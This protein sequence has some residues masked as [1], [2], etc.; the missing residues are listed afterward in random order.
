MF[1]YFLSILTLEANSFKCLNVSEKA[2]LSPGSA[3]F[4]RLEEEVS[5][6]LSKSVFDIREHKSDERKALSEIRAD[7]IETF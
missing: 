7:S 5:V 2:S 4:V 6:F 3:E 1:V